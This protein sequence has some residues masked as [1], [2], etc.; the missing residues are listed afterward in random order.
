M[1]EQPQNILDYIKSIG[2]V[3]GG[4]ESLKVSVAIDS[5]SALMIF[6]AVF[7]SVLAAGAILKRI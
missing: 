7:L 6:L 2:S 3:A 1:Q 5:Y 4:R